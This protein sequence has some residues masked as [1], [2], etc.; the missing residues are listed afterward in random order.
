MHFGAHYLPAYVPELDGTP[1][2]FYGKLFAQ[3]EVL[4]DLGFEHLWV[5]E[6]HFHEYGG[7]IPD[8]PTFLA[9]VARGTKR[10]HLGVAV[11]VIP[12]H[13]PLQ[14]AESYAMVDVI[15]NGRL[16]LGLGRGTTLPEFAEFRVSRDDSPTR[17]KETG[18]ILLQAWSGEPVNFEGE[19]YQY[20]NV[21]VLPRP[22]QQPP[23]VWVGASRTDGTFRWAGE[24]GFHLMTLPYMY[25]A[26]HLTQSVAAYKEGLASGGHD[27]SKKEFLGKF[28][29]FV[30]DSRADAERAVP[31]LA[32]YGALSS[33]RSPQGNT[34]TRRA[35][36]LEDSVAKGEII[37]GD[38]D[39]CIDIIKYWQDT[40]GIT[41]ITGTFFF[42][43]MPQDMAIKNIQMFAKEVMPAFATAGVAG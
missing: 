25:G 33:V 23:R 17:L 29:V 34:P 21:R 37:V 9:A 14:L 13:N 22:V 26:E 39:T 11:S 15:S 31:Y 1:S 43:G 7:M 4:D 32:N 40:F 35:K 6:H 16:E 10:I 18:E 38:P 30:A 27:F 5:T 20:S 8:P 41:T 36:S 2:E 42:G 24:M 19:I 3:A 28:H 12:F